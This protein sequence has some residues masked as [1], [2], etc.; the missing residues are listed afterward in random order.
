MKRINSVIWGALLMAVG[1][2]FALNAFEVTHINLLFDGWWTLFI[3]IPCAVGFITNA[4]KTDNLIGLAIG[5]FLLL[6]CRDVLAFDLV[7][8]LLVAALIVYAG[9]K[10]ILG[11][12]FKRKF[13]T[14]FQDSCANEQR[15]KSCNALFSGQDL[16][17]NGQ[18]FEGAKLS[19]AFGGIKCDLRGAIIEKDCT[20]RVSVAFGG[21]DVLVPEG[22]RV[23]VSVTPVFGG[24]DNK[25]SQQNGV[26]TIYISGSCVFG[27]VDV[28]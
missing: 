17:F 23:Q 11:S 26:H 5:V 19:A 10:L 9:V 1:V 14:A 22:V 12:I 20:I 8:K 25:V 7:W 2:I 27:G 3:I 6:A 18:V 15:F 16:Y 4:N 21:I 24:V 28:K 13:D